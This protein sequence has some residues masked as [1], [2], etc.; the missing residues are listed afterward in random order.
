MIELSDNLSIVVITDSEYNAIKSNEAAK[1]KE[2]KRKYGKRA[3]QARQL[4]KP[5]YSPTGE[6]DVVVVE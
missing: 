5:D 6:I 4:S 1:F 3:N 2:F